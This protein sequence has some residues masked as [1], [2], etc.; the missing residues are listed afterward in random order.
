MKVLLTRP[1][2]GR[3]AIAKKKMDQNLAN[4]DRI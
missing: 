1:E 4:K 3:L 2:Y